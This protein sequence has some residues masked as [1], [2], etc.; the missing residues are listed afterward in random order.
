MPGQDEAIWLSNKKMLLWLSKAVKAKR[1]P[2]LRAVT[3]G[4]GRGNDASGGGPPSS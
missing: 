3:A 1:K 2:N 4:N